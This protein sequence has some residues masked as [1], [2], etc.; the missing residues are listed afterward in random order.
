ML[1]FQAKAPPWESAS[2]TAPPAIRRN[3][4]SWM[5]PRRTAATTSQSSCGL[6]PKS[7]TGK[8]GEKPALC[9]PQQQK[10]GQGCQDQRRN[11]AQALRRAQRHKREEGR[12]GD[13]CRPPAAVEEMPQSCGVWMAVFVAASS[14]AHTQENMP[15]GRTQSHTSGIRRE[16]TA[17]RPDS[18]GQ[19]RCGAA[20]R[21]SRSPCQWRARRRRPSRSGSPVPSSEE[22]RRQC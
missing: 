21:R 11:L 5:V 9:L 18:P 8:A 19:T 20:N 15:A 6:M 14:R 12:F 10:G 4:R 3:L 16:M 13:P 2:D 1:R 7:D 22:C 17:I